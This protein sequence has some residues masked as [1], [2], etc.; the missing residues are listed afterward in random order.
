LDHL[1]TDIGNAI[2]MGTSGFGSGPFSVKVPYKASFHSGAQEG[3]VVLYDENGG[4]A[5]LRGGV[6]MVKVLLS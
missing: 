1:Y 6:A 4:G 2:A 5:S 3:I